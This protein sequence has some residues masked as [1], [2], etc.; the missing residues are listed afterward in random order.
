[1]TGKAIVAVMMCGALAL[2]SCGSVFDDLDP[3]PGG[4]RMRFVYDYN[5]ESANAFPAQVDCLTLHIYDTDGNFVTT[6]TETTDVLADENWRMTI[7]LAP[8]HYRAIAYGGIACSL[9]PKRLAHGCTTISTALSISTSTPTHWTI[10]RKPSTCPK[11][12]IISVS[13]S[14]SSTATP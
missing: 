4:V 5:L 7:D 1:M 9:H 12:Q 14:S 13:S 3:C 2:S 10:P 8:G 11:L 6:V